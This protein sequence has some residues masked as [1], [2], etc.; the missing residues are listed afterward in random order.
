MPAGLRAREGIK[1]K[2]RIG[3]AVCASLATVG[4]VRA[5]QGGAEVVVTAAR[6]EQALTDAIPATTVITRERI[7][8]SQ[9]QDLVTLLR[10]EAGIEVT[11]NGGMGTVTGVFMRGNG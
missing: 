4:G 8:A 5:Q 6:M 10:R 9:V 2:Q 7:A 11:Q 3:L 1:V